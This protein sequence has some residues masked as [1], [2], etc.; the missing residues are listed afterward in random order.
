MVEDEDGDPGND[1]GWRGGVSYVI[2]V[3]SWYIHLL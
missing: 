3:F 2:V 1:G